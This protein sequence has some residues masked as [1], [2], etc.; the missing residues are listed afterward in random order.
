[1]KKMTTTL[2]LVLFSLPVFAPVDKVIDVVQGDA[3]NPYEKIWE[4][5]CEVESAQNPLAYHMESNG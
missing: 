3:I 5:V 1:M 2:I 4:A